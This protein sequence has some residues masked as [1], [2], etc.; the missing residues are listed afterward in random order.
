MRYGRERKLPEGV[1]VEFFR[2]PAG[3]GRAEREPG[4]GQLAC[5]LM[6]NGRRLGQRR[7]A[8]IRLSTGVPRR[9]RP[10]PRQTYFVILSEAK[11]LFP[12]EPK[13][14]DGLCLARRRETNAV[15]SRIYFG[16]GCRCFAALNMT[17]A[18]ALRKEVKDKRSAVKHLYRQHRFFVA[19][20]L[21][22]TKREE[23]RSAQRVGTKLFIV[24]K[25]RSR[26]E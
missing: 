23:L 14:A 26:L 21:R 11:N 20:L 8:N 2:C 17:V 19:M 18:A 12:C 13:A 3:A 16:Q 6:E 7:P 10:N 25:L 22:M 4:N 24:R 15:Q 9:L 5:R 1:L